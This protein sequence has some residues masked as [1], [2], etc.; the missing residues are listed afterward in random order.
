M[1][2]LANINDLDNIIKII[3]E[4]QK[5][6]KKE[7]NPQWN[8]EED[9][10]S[11]AKFTS[12]IENNDLYVYEHEN[13][14]KGFIAITKD[15]GEYN[16]LLKT[17]NKP[18]FILHRLAIRKDNRKEGIAT[19][20]L[21]YAEDLANEDN[22]KLLKADTEEHNIKMNNLFIKLGYIKKGEFEYDDYPGHYI[23]YEKELNQGAKKLEKREIWKF[24]RNISLICFITTIIIISIFIGNTN[25]IFFTTLLFWPFLI[26]FPII[27]FASLILLIISLFKLKQIKKSKE[28]E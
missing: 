12:D 20:L 27:L 10:P 21:N 18:A 28:D 24:L 15:N 8:E 26:S 13:K 9:Y 22:I 14:I 5:E 7:N 4:I 6:M 1:I 16:E 23:Y 3:K 19:I 2:R 11:K 25:I 17:T